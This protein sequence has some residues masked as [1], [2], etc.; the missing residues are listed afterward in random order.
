MGIEAWSTTASNNNASPPNGWPEGQ[1]ASTVNDCARQMMASL[2]AWFEDAQWI[3]FGHTPTR[4]SGTQFT[5][6]TDLTAIYHVGRRLKATGSA[7]G[8]ATI[9]ASSYSSPNTTVTVAMDSG[10]L[11][12]TL[13]AVAVSILS[14]TNSAVPPGIFGTIATDKLLGRDTAGT[15]GVE[16]IGVSGGLEF[17]GSGGIQ[18]S[19]LTGDATAS[20]GS[21][22]V[23]IPNN[24]VTFAKMQDI[25]TDSLIGR[26][27]A[28]SGDPENITLNATLSMTGAGALQRAAL[29]GDVT[30]SAGSNATTIANDA[31]TNAKAANM[32][33][34]TIKGRTSG[35]GTGDPVDLTAAQAVA[36]LNGS[37]TRFSKDV[38]PDLVA[39]KAAQTAR[40]ST[41]TQTADPDLTVSVPGAGTYR[42]EMYLSFNAGVGG[43]QG[44]DFGFS[45]SGTGPSPV[46]RSYI[47]VVNGTLVNRLTNNVGALGTTEQFA[48]ITTVTA[49]DW[50]KVTGLFN[51]SNAGT[52][53]LTW[54]QH[55]S[56]AN[57]TLLNSGSHM[58]LKKVGG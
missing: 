57:A 4:L 45:Y 52:F 51:F 15:G 42:L 26:D 25:A 44:F 21:N 41:I 40:S 56:S 8:Y 3:N 20:A 22:A 58:I 32:A 49:G 7:T 33:Q 13:S 1:A 53:A 16:Q 35:A 46:T 14:F 28:A 36:I 17:T 43:T 19:A 54:A 27:T 5:V 31:V 11:P 9:T 24:T 10:S 34:D 47:G 48:T 55:S 12:T 30:A 38:M 39:W 6:A 50:L 18:R 37:T 29:T 2:R 23:T